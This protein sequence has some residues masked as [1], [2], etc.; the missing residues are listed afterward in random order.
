MVWLLVD[1]LHC[2]WQASFPRALGQHKLYS[3]DEKVR[4]KRRRKRRLE[5]KVSLG[6]CIWEEERML[7]NTLN[8]IPK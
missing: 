7:S 5:V 2:T 6:R 1:R 8:K 3:V 4:R